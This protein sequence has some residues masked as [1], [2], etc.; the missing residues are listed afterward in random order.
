MMNYVIIILTNLSID[1]LRG[2]LDDSRD[3]VGCWLSRHERRIAFRDFGAATRGLY[4]GENSMLK[5][6]H[7]FTNMA[8]N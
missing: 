8:F 5:F 1:E 6:N 3:M 4:Y 2:S 7:K